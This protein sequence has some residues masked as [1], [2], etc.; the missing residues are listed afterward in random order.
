MSSINLLHHTITMIRYSITEYINRHKSTTAIHP[1]KISGTRVCFAPQ[2]VQLNQDFSKVVLFLLYSNFPGE[3]KSTCMAIY[4]GGESG[5]EHSHW[6]KTD[7]RSY[8]HSV[9]SN[10]NL[11]ALLPKGKSIILYSR[12]PSI[13][14]HKIFPYPLQVILSSWW[15]R[16][17]NQRNL[18][19]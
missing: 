4:C 2:W 5:A 19:C 17:F 11:S 18:K 12:N 14:Y 6:A 13:S 7:G 8:Y 9:T 10:H 15:H 1:H 16:T 3:Y